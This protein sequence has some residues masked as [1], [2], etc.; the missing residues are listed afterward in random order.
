V[1]LPSAAQGSL[2]SL[3]LLLY[4]FAKEKSTHPEPS[5]FCLH[6][7]PSPFCPKVGSRALR[8]LRM[9]GRVVAENGGEIIREVRSAPEICAVTLQ[10]PPPVVI[11]KV[12]KR[13]SRPGGHYGNGGL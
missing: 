5:P 1:S 13:Q 9:Y 12:E 6:P 2:F 10:V 7:K 11:L 3:I 8:R 4:I